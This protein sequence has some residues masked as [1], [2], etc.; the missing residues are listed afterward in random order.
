MRTTRRV[1]DKLERLPTDDSLKVTPLGYHALS[2]TYY[3]DGSLPDSW[4][5]IE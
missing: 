2:T 4:L 1:S 3:D 5:G